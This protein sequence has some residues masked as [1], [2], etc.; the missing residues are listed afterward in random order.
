ME[1]NKESLTR[2]YEEI[3]SEKKKKAD[4]LVKS[5][6]RSIAICFTGM[7]YCLI[8]AFPLLLAWNKFCSL[9]SLSEMNFQQSFCL[10][11]FIGMLTRVFNA[12]KGDY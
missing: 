2:S 5:I 7:V 12:W 4:R 10:C 8:W 3:Y 6:A 1:E 11:A 9:F